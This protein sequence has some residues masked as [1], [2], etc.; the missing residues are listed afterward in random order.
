MQE[1]NAT[2]RG[3]RLN[4]FVVGISMVC[5][6]FSVALLSRYRWALWTGILA[7]LGGIGVTAI[8]R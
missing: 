7:A 5:I 8:R 6:L 4:E 2:R 1:A 3:H